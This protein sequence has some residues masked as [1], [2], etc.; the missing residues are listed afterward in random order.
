MNVIDAIQS[1]RSIRRFRQDTVPDSVLMR[2]ADLAR[3]YPSGGNAQPIR[4]AIVSREPLRSDVFKMLRWAMYLS[5]YQPKEDQRPTA[6]LILLSEQPNCW[7]DVGAAAE[8]IALSAQEF[9]LSSCCMQPAEP[10]RLR[11]LLGIADPMQAMLVIA[12]GYGDHESQFVPAGSDL[13][14]YLLHDDQLAVPKL[15]LEQTL[16]FSDLPPTDGVRDRTE[17]R[18]H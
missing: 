7:F 6:Y 3:L 17:R 10:A 16:V 9:G 11:E 14:Y 13:R 4:T 18:D 12:L 1:R 15:N 2:L 5:D 8:I